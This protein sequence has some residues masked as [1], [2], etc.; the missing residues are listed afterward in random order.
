MT[1]EIRE[2]RLTFAFLRPLV[3]SLE[4]QLGGAGTDLS[5]GSSVGGIAEGSTVEIDQARP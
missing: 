4:R 1:S 2:Y 5:R 3:S